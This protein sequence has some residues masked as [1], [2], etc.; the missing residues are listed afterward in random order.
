MTT[1]EWKERIAP[2]LSP[3]LERA[4]EAIMQTKAVQS[5]LRRAAAEAA[6]GL[7]RGPGLEAELQGYAQMKADLEDHLPNLVAA[8]EAL[9]EGCGTVDLE[10]QPHQPNRSR[11][12]VSFDR[13]YSVEAFCRLT[14]CTPQ[15]ARDALA[16]V[17]EALPEG[18]PFPNRPNVVT[19]LVARDGTGVGVR[20]QE[21]RRSDEAGTTRRVTLLPPDSPDQ[22][23]LSVSEA[24]RQLRQLLCATPGP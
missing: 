13:D 11:V 6:E 9:T 16:T 23:S 15:A 12:Y 4:S 2:H 7:G 8:V 19:G 24:G 17:L 5:W 20:V 3:S 21:H 18:E 10:W 1:D 22:E 14:D